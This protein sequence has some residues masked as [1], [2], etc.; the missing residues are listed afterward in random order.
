[1]IATGGDGPG[2][3]HVAHFVRLVVGVATSQ[4]AKLNSK[5]WQSP[6]HTIHE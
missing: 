5:H 1:M 2:A 6:G 3:T 4:H